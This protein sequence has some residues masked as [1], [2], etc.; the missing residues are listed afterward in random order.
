MRPPV[1]AGTMQCWRAAL[2]LRR[3]SSCGRPRTGP[4]PQGPCAYERTTPRPSQ[5]EHRQRH[6]PGFPPNAG[7]AM[8]LSC[9]PIAAL[10]PAGA[11]SMPTRRTTDQPYALQSAGPRSWAPH[12]RHPRRWR[13]VLTPPPLC[14]VLGGGAFTTAN[15]PSRRTYLGGGG[16]PS[17]SPPRFCLAPYGPGSNQNP[18][19]VL[20][21]PLQS[22]I[23]SRA[24]ETQLGKVEAI[25]DPHAPR[26]LLPNN[27][28]HLCPDTFPPLPMQAPL[29]GEPPTRTT[30]CLGAT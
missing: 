29:C 28:G 18:Q 25:D 16:A 19:Q 17:P 30:T 9:Q 21:N 8:P 10:H 24:L 23:P 5:P 2:W 4:G 27:S 14:V 6:S 22:D 3:P 26:L 12:D 15:R 1:G 11:Q 7:R 13:E 20:R